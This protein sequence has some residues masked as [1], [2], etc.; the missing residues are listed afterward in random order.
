[1][2]SR[3]WRV[4]VALAAFALV[5]LI[6]TQAMAAPDFTGTPT[7]GLVELDVTFDGYGYDASTDSV[8]WDFGNGATWSTTDTTL[9]P[10]VQT[11]TVA[12]DSF[13]VTIT[14]WVGGAP[15]SVTKPDY[16][17]TAGID[18]TGSPLLGVVPLTVTF[19]PSFTGTPDSVVWDFG[20][21]DTFS[22]VAAPF[23]SVQ[24]AYNTG[25]S[26]F[27][28]SMA[29]WY[30]GGD[31]TVSKTDYVQTVAPSI[32]IDS[33]DAGSCNGVPN[34][35][36]P[37]TVHYTYFTPVGVTG[38]WFFVDTNDVVFDSA[39]VTAASQTKF[40]YVFEWFDTFT[41]TA[42]P[43][44]ADSIWTSAIDSIDYITNACYCVKAVNDGYDTDENT[45]LVAFLLDNDTLGIF[46]DPRAVDTIY[47][48]SG[49]N[50]ADSIIYDTNAAG[51]WRINYYPKLNYHG[52]DTVTYIV[53]IEDGCAE[54]TATV[55]ITIFSDGIVG[56][57]SL[58]YLWGGPCNGCGDPATISLGDT[59]QIWVRINPV[60]VQEIAPGWPKVWFPALGGNPAGEVM[61]LDTT[62][63]MGDDSTWYSIP[64]QNPSTTG[65]DWRT[66]TGG[67]V[68]VSPGFSEIWAR[69]VSDS[70]LSS[71]DTTKIVERVDTRAPD[72]VGNDSISVVLWKDLNGNGIINKDDTV[73]FYIDLRNN[74]I[75]DVTYLGGNKE[76]CDVT[77]TLFDWRFVG[78]TLE[79]PLT[80]LAN[81]NRFYYDY[82]VEGGILDSVLSGSADLNVQFVVTDNAC[83][84]DTVFTT[85]ENAD[86]IDIVSPELGNI[87][88]E[89]RQPPYGS[90]GDVD[91]NGCLKAGEYV[92]LRVYVPSGSDVDSVF[93][94]FLGSGIGSETPST[95]WKVPLQRDNPGDT[96]WYIVW[97]LQGSDQDSIFNPRTG[98]SA[99][100]AVDA[101]STLTVH[102]TAADEAGN[103]DTAYSGPLLYCVDTD[104]PFSIPA[105]SISCARYP[106]PGDSTFDVIELTW[107]YH[108]PDAAFFEIQWNDDNGNP[109]IDT[110]LAAAFGAPMTWRS[111]STVHPV[112]PCRDYDFKIVTVDDCYNRDYFPATFTCEGE[113]PGT[114]AM[115]DCQQD[116]CG[117]I[118]VRWN[119][120]GFFGAYEVWWNRGTLG[121]P[122]VKLATISDGLDTV[123]STWDGVRAAANTT[124]N[125]AQLSGLVPLD[126]GNNYRFTV[127]GIDTCNN[128]FA[129]AD[130]L[131]GCEISAPNPVNTFTCTSIDSGHIQL[132]WRSDAVAR[133]YFIIYM[134]KDGVIDFTNPVDTVEVTTIQPG[135][136]TFSWKTSDAGLTTGPP[137]SGADLVD[138]GWYDFSIITEDA[139]GFQQDEPADTVQCLSDMAPPHACIIQPEPGDLHCSGND[140]R[141]YVCALNHPLDD[142]IVSVTVKGRVVGTTTWVPL[143][144]SSQADEEICFDVVLNAGTLNSLVGADTTKTIEL[145]VTPTD[146]VGKTLS[147][148]SAYATCEHFTFDWSTEVLDAEIVTV[149]GNVRTYQDYC[150]LHGYDVF[151]ADNEVVLSVED[152]QAPYKVQV[153]I[154]GIDVFYTEFSN[155]LDTINIDM[156]GFGK[157]AHE[158]AVQWWDLCGR[159][160]GALDSLCVGDSLGPCAEITNPVDGKCIRKSRSMQDPVPVT[161]TLDPDDNC[162]DPDDVFK[163][164]FEWALECCIGD[165]P[166]V[167]RVCDTTFNPT[168]DTALCDT[169][170]LGAIGE[171][172]D[173]IICVDTTVGG[174]VVRCY[175]STVLVSCDTT[176]WHTFAIEPGE[177]FVDGEVTTDWFNRHVIDSLGLGDGEIIYLRARVYDDQENITIT[178][179]VAVCI[180]TTTPPL[181]LWSPDVCYGD[182]KEKLSGEVDFIAHLDITQDVYDD[183]EDV[184][185]WYKKSSD[186][187]QLNYW[188]SLGSGFFD[189][190]AGGTRETGWRWDDI[191]TNNFTQ[192]VYYDF[193]VIAKTIWGTYSYDFD[194][195]FDFDAGTFDT[196]NGDAVTFFIDNEAPGIAI[197]TVWTEIDDQVLGVTETVVQPNTSCRL[198]D[199]RGWAFM[200]FGKTIEV[201]PSVYP[202]AEADDIAKIEW[203][204]WDGDCA[205]CACEGDP[206]HGEVNFFGGE[207]QQGQIC[208][209]KVLSVREGEGVLDHVTLDP[210]IAPFVTEQNGFQVHTLTVTIW[211]SCGNMS[212]DCI[213]LYILDVTPSEA[214]I[215]DPMNDEVFCQDHE[216]DGGG[217]EIT[218]AGLL[219]NQIKE[220]SFYYRAEGATEWTLI[221]TVEM[222]G[223]GTFADISTLWYP[224]ALGL[225]DGTYELKA[226]AKDYSLN[227][228]TTEYVTRVHL[229]CGQPTVTMVNPATV[230]PEFEF[231]NNCGIELTAEAVASDAYNTIE[232]VCFYY[233]EWTKNEANLIDCDE[234]S[235]GT[236]FNYHWDP[237]DDLSADGKYYIWAVAT[238]KAGVSVASEKVLVQY[239]G[240][241]P[242]TRVIEVAGDGS[243]GGSG[244]PT[245][246]T[247]GEDVDIY[248]IARDNQSP[249]GYGDLDNCGVDSVKV[250]VYNSAN[251]KVFGELMTVDP[252]IDSLYMV[253]WPT[254]GLPNGTYRVQ[255][256]VTDCACNDGS[257]SYW[258]VQV[259]NPTD[260]G[261]IAINEAVDVCGVLSISSENVNINF[262][263][264]GNVD[265]SSVVIWWSPM[266]SSDVYDQYS[267]PTPNN[268]AL[269]DND[270]DGVWEPI[271]DFDVSALAEGDY[272]VRAVVTSSQG[273]VSDDY[274]NN[275]LFDDFTFDEAKSHHM[276]VRVDRSVTPFTVDLSAYT[277]AKGSDVT[278]TVNPDEECD[279]AEVCY[280]LVAQNGNAAVDTCIGELQYT[281][282]PSDSGLVSLRHGVWYGPVTV[283]VTD[284][285]G[286][287]MEWVDETNLYVLDITGDEAMV[288]SPEWGDFVTGDEVTVVARKLTSGSVSNLDF[289]YGGATGGGTEISG[290]VT[291]SGDE[292]MITWDLSEVPAGEYYLWTSAADNKRV[293]VTVVKVDADFALMDPMPHYTRTVFNEELM[294]VGGRV[295][296][297]VDA[298]TLEN[299]ELVDSIVFAYR[300][301]DAPGV[302]FEPDPE[303]GWVIFGVDRYG[304][305]CED[306]FTD[307]DF[308]L[309]GCRDGHYSVVAW[310]YYKGGVANHSQVVDVMVDNTDPYSEIVDIDGD[311]TFG[312]CHEIIIT[313]EQQEVKFSAVAIDDRSCAGSTPE[314]NSGAMTMQFFVG[315][316]GGS[317]GGCVDIVWVIDGSGSMGD[318]QAQ[319]ASQ[320]E[321]FFNA[322]GGLD[323]RMGVL[324][325][326]DVSNPVSTAG[327]F[328]NGG[329]GTGDFTT[330]LATFQTMVT[331]VGDT[332]SGT[333]N[334]LTAINDA[335]NWYNFRANC[336]KAI[337]LVTDEDA[338]DIADFNSL[339][340]GILSSGAQISTVF[341]FGDS[342]GYSTL[343]PRTN[344]AQ[345]DITSNWG[346]NLTA[347]AT[348]ISGGGGA[349]GDVGIIWGKQVT[350]TDGQDDAFALWDPTGVPE[351]NYCAW[352]VVVDEVGNMYQSEVRSICI[353][354]RTPPVGYVAGFGVTTDEHM[355]NEY[356]IMGRTWDEDVERV[357]FQWRQT[358][359][360]SETD[361]TGIG[362]AQRINGDSTCWMT[363]WNPCVWSGTQLEF[364]MVPTDKSGNQDFEIQP[365]F[366]GTVN[367]CEVTP[368]GPSAT[369]QAEVAFEDKTFE[370]LGLVHVN[371]NAPNFHHSMMA[372]YADH[373]GGFQIE[374]VKLFQDQGQT[375]HMMGSFDDSQILGGGYGWFWV[376]YNDDAGVTFLNQ[377]RL[378]VYHVET[379]LGFPGCVT[380][381]SFGAQVCLDPGATPAN[382]GVVLFPA[383]PPVLALTQQYIQVW[384]HNGTNNLGNNYVTAIRLTDPLEDGFMI[385]KYAKVTLSYDADAVAAAGIDEN[386]L[387]VGWWDGDEWNTVDDMIAGGEIANGTA[388]FYTKN[389]H[390]LYAVVS[391]G[392]AC[393]SGALTVEHHSAYPYYVGY[394]GNRPV[395]KTLVRSNIHGDAGNY[396]IDPSMI[397]VKVDGITVYSRGD[398]AEGWL[399]TWDNT[400]G[401]LTTRPLAT[402]N[403]D[404]FFQELGNLYNCFG[405]LGDGNDYWDFC[406][407]YDGD[408]QYDCDDDNVGQSPDLCCRL[409]EYL[410]NYYDCVNGNPT[411]TGNYPVMPLDCGPHTI[412]VQSFNRAGYCDS[413][414]WEFNI[415]CNEPDIAVETGYVCP[416]PTFAFE[417]TDDAS[418]VNWDSVYVD[419]YEYTPSW[420]D[421]QV[422]KARLLHTETPDAI[423]DS[424]VGDSVYIS[425]TFNQ[426]EYDGFRIVIYNGNRTRVFN[427]ECD[428]EYYVYDHND[429]GVPDMVGNR[430]EIVE[431]FFTVNRA[432]CEGD[433]GGDGEDIKPSM[434]PFDPFAGDVVTFPLNG[435][436][437]G[438][439]TIHAAVYDLTGAKVATLAEDGFGGFSW[440]GR[441]D[442]GDQVAE[443]VYLV[444]FHKT[445][446]AAGSRTSQAIK[447]VV[448]RAD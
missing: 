264:S 282:D 185:L 336:A 133:K 444:H 91:S 221:N 125:D 238:N 389:L 14:E 110:V 191:N 85:V 198:S 92:Q 24:H 94:D 255:T 67:N 319:I 111:D 345:L 326:T 305:M 343:A 436:R 302:P 103:R 22:D 435:F 105:D 360:S 260:L 325:Y 380:D 101:C 216:Q 270:N 241:D 402:D 199:P 156:T 379:D 179:C 98:D 18:F 122:S 227:E 206:A 393:N 281:F 419:V 202:F 418:G 225:E 78:D 417:I 421:Q 214:V 275:G 273:V 205:G 330:D 248:A 203:R 54:D 30:P 244:D 13:D 258:Y 233:T 6:A 107:T 196:A 390:G 151:G 4:L 349:G 3:N 171:D 69:I 313:G 21:G 354:D 287:T 427:D 321:N 240:T 245:T 157:G 177:A 385:G 44:N 445:G 413:D 149:N 234:Y 422:R 143:G 27:S 338:D 405:V 162:I 283:Q 334:G 353:E 19:T 223:E 153:T 25:P 341:N 327:V 263:E 74:P 346:G 355:N 128:H 440:D 250:Y 77:A 228:Q 146:L 166:Q 7:F 294:F 224:H 414:T 120:D 362:L 126:P 315:E 432:A 89:Y 178:P 375:G 261:T 23:T 158:I 68:E 57:D 242:W 43:F 249:L 322:M 9:D 293:P 317:F 342:T 139:C 416:N 329:S 217:I 195:D 352:T 443:G 396:D 229:S 73:R 384:G 188:T 211:D 20:D 425:L 411:Y 373:D 29:V 58:F 130:T 365:I 378:T 232:D 243:N 441:T 36:L 53:A 129:W 247:A 266:T 1:M 246:V 200:Q 350:L 296:I 226:V 292:F 303:D 50:F 197:D 298:E 406:Y 56:I 331:A 280:G 168:G 374:K 164:D 340:P 351:G 332:G 363:T 395:I 357:Q 207:N 79:L 222:S 231:L 376:A 394:A 377:S 172:I 194:G 424:R 335:L 181:V 204:L 186:P 138:R 398:N 41:V 15:T 397:T 356:Y 369:S 38:V 131:T 386:Q 337:I 55:F 184:T 11:Y 407:Y 442:N 274:D 33:V 5:P 116:S 2:K 367:N 431:E 113:E 401:I 364:R 97:Q 265:V 175:D 40:D 37:D 339:V 359:S 124:I 262:T 169:F 60:D 28:V 81:D 155:G 121:A 434:N 309:G 132:N 415:D 381:E 119:P 219:N 148:D 423:D 201:Q 278:I 400:S 210:G 284:P 438:G 99:M 372:F 235:T 348:Q 236:L 42:Q 174:F 408:G 82:K 51:E 108:D 209:S 344:G 276:I 404:D 39:L 173:S 333:E 127:K 70:G 316:C 361:W 86:A 141:V 137:N 433:V 409:M 347:L 295:D 311:E 75:N 144:S 102:I 61:F 420:N 448:K 71:Y 310:A 192:L 370:N 391:T 383:R 410:R 358:G 446:A 46:N 318:D 93:A 106:V 59:L 104:I 161:L 8:T 437:S 12:G 176:V 429:Q 72:A 269:Q 65:S 428:C 62:G 152:G 170:P 63:V 163:V 388:T 256:V 114:L 324:A 150:D 87:F 215:V 134:G 80:D 117:G 218:A 285:L 147:N 320:A 154:D 34:S 109:I 165:I 123:F 257:Y 35:V 115:V 304:S 90:H 312:D 100:A 297:C 140:L 306:W 83:N 187:D 88:F 308:D 26:M 66:I 112:S 272:R 160:A 208:E 290:T 213:S 387:A 76:I 251:V 180:D 254:A 366:T 382:N 16:I 95:S 64:Y 49:G 189:V 230:E 368:S 430:T 371:T 307:L 84:V 212:T 277:I 267:R 399:S 299:R 289:F 17:I 142:D 183:I 96:L 167:I 48:F 286:N 412:E 193:R 45:P 159:S 403:V 237:S 323:F 220:V 118:R 268:G 288:V 252:T 447:I 145:I 135:N 314:F 10:P 426:A 253:T 31:S 182:G 291:Q 392:R 136:Q 439:G 300:Y 301:G 52:K 47:T 190:Q 328:E 259:I 279:V 32:V 271:V 239:D